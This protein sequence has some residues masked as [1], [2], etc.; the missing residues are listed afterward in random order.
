MNAVLE[1]NNTINQ[2]L[3]QDQLRHEL[4]QYTGTTQWYRHNINKKI[5]YTEGV[6]FF[7]EKGGNQGA[8]WFVDK[9]ACQIAPLMKAKKEPFGCISLSVGLTD[10]NQAMILVT[11]GNEKEL[12]SYHIHLTDMQPGIWKFY[13]IDDETHITLL[14]PSEY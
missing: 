2:S 8:Y 14:L 6:Q 9:V 4:A 5:L 1:K 11:D 12:A 3:T 13:L 7:A 10:K